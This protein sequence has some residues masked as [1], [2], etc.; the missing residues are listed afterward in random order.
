LSILYSQDCQVEQNIRDDQIPV[1]ALLLE[2]NQRIPEVPLRSGVQLYLLL[3]TGQKEECGDDLPQLTGTAIQRDG[4]LAQP[5]SFLG[6]TVFVP[7]KLSQAA[8]RLSC[9]KRIAGC[10]GVPERLVEQRS[11]IIKLPSKDCNIRPVNKPL[12][13]P[14]HV[15]QFAE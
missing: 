3:D 14:I 1:Q 10:A 9:T 11:R 13:Q 7:G 2:Q 15:F 8:H 12:V 5:G 6:I 4:L